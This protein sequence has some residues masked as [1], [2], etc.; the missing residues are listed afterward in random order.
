MLCEVQRPILSDDPPNDDTE[1]DAEDC[2][3]ESE[4]AMPAQPTV[5]AD[6]SVTPALPPPPNRVRAAP[7]PCPSFLCRTTTTM[8]VST[9]SRVL[10]CLDLLEL[11]RF[12]PVCRAWRDSIDCSPFFFGAQPYPSER[13]WAQKGFEFVTVDPAFKFALCPIP[14]TEELSGNGATALLFRSV[15][16]LKLRVHGEW[17]LLT[18]LFLSFFGKKAV[19]KRARNELVARCVVKRKGQLHPVE[20]CGRELESSRASAVEGGGQP[21]FVKPTPTDSDWD[22]HEIVSADAHILLF[23]CEEELCE[24]VDD[25][26]LDF[27]ASESAIGIE[28]ELSPSFKVPEAVLRLRRR[29]EEVERRNG[30][31][32]VVECLPWGLPPAL[33]SVQSESWP[34]KQPLAALAVDT[35]VIH[36]AP[37]A[38]TAEAVMA[39]NKQHAR[40][41]LSKALKQYLDNDG[42]SVVASDAPHEKP[43][44]TQSLVSLADSVQTFGSQ[45]LA[46]G[47]ECLEY[48]KDVGSVLLQS[49][50]L[51]S[52]TSAFFSASS[53]LMPSSVASSLGWWST[54][55][56]KEESKEE[57]KEDTPPPAEKEGEQDDQEWQQ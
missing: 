2:V 25:C 33:P 53:R 9:L 35:A 46:M 15:P 50:L 38:C 30:L 36:L 11:M 17:G 21:L 34:L 45:G 43:T 26:D 42:F 20:V 8:E 51:H 49:S 27:F 10:E 6:I 1:D 56:T 47:F 7:P 41:A 5:L 16:V 18:A 24:P 13:L 55:E 39:R 28:E 32:S 23:P 3:T 14:S 37:L 31:E 44:L 22:R 52:T 29:I 4:Q 57:G 12:R 19:L 48:S 54:E 40:T